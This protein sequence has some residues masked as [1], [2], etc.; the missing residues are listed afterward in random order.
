MVQ[1]EIDPGA[2]YHIILRPDS[3]ARS[4]YP[5]NF[6]E[7]E[8]NRAIYKRKYSGYILARSLKKT[9]FKFQQASNSNSNSLNV[10]MN[11]RW[12]EKT[13]FT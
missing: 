4:G 11:N 13:R 6:L 10:S 9:S 5:V 7:K 1:N 2:I 8:N 12:R 3:G